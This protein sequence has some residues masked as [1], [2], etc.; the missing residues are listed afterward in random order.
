MGSKVEFEMEVEV[1][2]E[3]EGSPGHQGQKRGE[4]NVCFRSDARG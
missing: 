2:I 4:A 3:V 1:E